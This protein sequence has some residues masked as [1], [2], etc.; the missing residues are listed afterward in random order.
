MLPYFLIHRNH[1]LQQLLTVSLR[2]SD[3]LLKVQ[4]KKIV[5]TKGDILI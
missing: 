3:M 2:L 1:Y 5:D 4:K